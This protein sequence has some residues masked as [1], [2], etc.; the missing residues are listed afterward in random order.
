M[1]VGNEWC[2]EPSRIKEEVLRFYKERFISSRDIQMFLDNVS[3]PVISSEDNEALLK[4]ISMEDMKSAVWDCDSNKC[5]ERDDFNLNFFKEF[6][7]IIN[8]KLYKVVRC[9]HK[10]GR[11]PKECNA[12][13]I[14][15]I[16]K[17]ANSARL[18]DFRPIS[19]VGNL[20]KTKAKLLARRL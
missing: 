9:F 8:M 11:W 6:W 10:W 14:T 1:L 5:P 4:T 12:P 18:E 20:Y 3:F 13:F 15:Y 2:E 7:K 16:P 17:I 19:L